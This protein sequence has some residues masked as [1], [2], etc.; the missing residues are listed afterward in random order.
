MVN[1]IKYIS[2][3]IVNIAFI[4][5]KPDNITNQTTTVSTTITTTNTVT[6]PITSTTKVPSISVTTIPTTTTK[7][8]TTTNKRLPSIN[9]YCGLGTELDVNT[10]DCNQPC[11]YGLSFECVN[12]KYNC[13]NVP[14]ICNPPV[15]EQIP[16]NQPV[17]DESSKIQT[18]NLIL[19]TSIIISNMITYTN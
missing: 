17:Y 18:N 6:I 14:N 5:A 9:Y 2:L 12:T 8:P 13:F 10:I 4:T 19:L 3:I 11:P 1:Y 7:I 16:I 15:I